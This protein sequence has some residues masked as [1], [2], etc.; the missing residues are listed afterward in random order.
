MRNKKLIVRRQRQREGIFKCF[1]CGRLSFLI[2]KVKSADGYQL[3]Q[4]SC[5]NSRCPVVMILR[6]GV[7]RI[8]NSFD[9]YHIMMDRYKELEYMEEMDSMLAER[10]KF[11][12]ERQ[13]EMGSSWHYYYEGLIEENE[14]IQKV[15]GMIFEK[16]GMID[17][18]QLKRI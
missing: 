17:A 4:G 6:I 9:Y 15:I 16:G 5:S 2:K 14:R 8:F 13:S 3:L 1:A 7:Y 10:I 12:K 11:L 18:D